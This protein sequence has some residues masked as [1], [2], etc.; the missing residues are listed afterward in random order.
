M[1]PKPG[2]CYFEIYAGTSGDIF[3][4]NIA[5]GAQPIAT[6]NSLDQGCEMFGDVDIPFFLQS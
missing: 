4:Q 5:G 6:F 2:G 3:L 1:N